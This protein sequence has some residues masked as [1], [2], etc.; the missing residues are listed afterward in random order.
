MKELS[1]EVRV[2]N[3]LIRQR[4]E[5]LGLSQVQLAEKAGVSIFSY[6]ALER[7][8]RLP[9]TASGEWTRSARLLASFFNVRPGDLFPS[10]ICDFGMPVMTRLVDSDEFVQLGQAHLPPVE[11]PGSEL[12]HEQLRERIGEALA[13]LSDREANLV[14]RRYGIDTVQDGATLEELA[15]DNGVSRE[16]VRQIIYKALNKLRHPARVRLLRPF[17]TG[18]EETRCACGKM[19]I[20]HLVN[21]AVRCSR[22]GKMV[23][24]G[25]CI[26]KN[27]DTCHECAISSRMLTCERCGSL[28][29]TLHTC[30]C[31]RALCSHCLDDCAD[32][33]PAKPYVP[34]RKY[35][36]IQITMDGETR[37]VSRGKQ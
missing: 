29:K 33:R 34:Y 23:V 10:T 4:R 11:P 2:R 13:T 37:S 5:E 25:C 3:N 21:P 9:R 17:V 35:H 27:I 30:H 28:N 32:C 26:E 7:M 6:G 16:R 20:E 36:R 22:C 15:Q 19:R 18:E 1:V 31:K 12:E 14:R 8:T 24:V